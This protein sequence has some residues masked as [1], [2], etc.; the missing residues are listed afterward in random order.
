VPGLFNLA[1]GKK[2]RDLSPLSME[3]KRE[4]SLNRSTSAIEKDLSQKSGPGA[5]NTQEK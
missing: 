5:A 1:D 2:T 4:G 3:P